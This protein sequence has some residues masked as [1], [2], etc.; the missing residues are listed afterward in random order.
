MHGVWGAGLC[1]GVLGLT[2]FAHSCQTRDVL[3]WASVLHAVC[4]VFADMHGVWE[5]E[6]L[7]NLY[8]Y[9][10]INYNLNFII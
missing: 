5:L 9:N 7:L 6:C 3:I 4:C 10:N 1:G 8:L 2:C